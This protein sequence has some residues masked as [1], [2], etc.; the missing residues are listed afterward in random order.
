VNREA[1][2]KRILE[3]QGKTAFTF[4][5]RAAGLCLNAIDQR[6]RLLVQAPTG[7]GKTL[8]SQLAIAVLALELRR[9]FPRVLVVVPSRGLLVQHVED[10]AWL[11]PSFGLAI[12]WLAPDTPMSIFEAT[13]R[14]FGVVHTT[15]VTMWNRL[16]ALPHG[17]ELLAGFDAAI[18]DEIDTYL[19]VD[20]LEERRDTGPALRMCVEMGLPII[21]FTGTH[22]NEQ[23]TR[24][25]IEHDFAM[26]KAEVPQ[27]WLPFIRVEFVAVHD[28][29]V[30]SEDERIRI[31]MSD[32]YGSLAAEAEV[33]GLPPPTWTAIKKMA[34]GGDS[35]A[36]KILGLCA[37]RLRLFE[38]PESVKVKLAAILAQVGK[39]G[40]TLLLAR[41]RDTAAVLERASAASVGRTFRADGSMSRADIGF[42]IND[43]RSLRATDRGVLVLTRELGGRG[44]DFPSAARVVLASPRSNYQAVAQELARIRSRQSAPKTAFITYFG[45][46]TEQAKARRLAI[47]L[48]SE[49]YGKAPLFNV[50]ELP[51]EFPGLESFARLTLLYDEALAAIDQS[52]LFH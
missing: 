26:I 47:H 39:P 20:E 1:R 13:M 38:S 49:K 2:A 41:F 21:G 42:A 12:H 6:R 3:K 11:A 24:T 30:E 25:W 7:S 17:R 9:R 45:N 32:A 23:Q 37:E 15:P 22:L 19:T 4:Q 16:S 35:R 28:S 51:P 36:L 43:F 14:A 31:E 29:T 27:N 5:A 44:L 48:S 34:L 52:P 10:A 33:V 50:T 8:I 40:P 46:T 18:F